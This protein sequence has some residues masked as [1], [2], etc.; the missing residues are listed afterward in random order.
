LGPATR[1]FLIKPSATA[2]IAAITVFV[3]F[4]ATTSAFGTPSGIA[5]W[6]DAAST[7]GTI[8]TMVALLMIAGAF[9]ISAGIT[10]GTTSC[11]LAILATTFKLPVPVAMIGS[12]GV[13]ILIGLT[14]GLL[15]VRT[16][17][18]SFIV[19]LAMF[20][21]L[22]G[23]NVA[24]TV[25]L[26]GGVSVGGIRTATWY[27]VPHSLFASQ[28]VIG[29]VG[30]QVSIVWWLLLTLA[31]SWVLLRTTFGN[32]IQAIG[33]NVLAARAQGVPVGRTKVL[34]F[35]GV[36]CSAWL[37]GTENALRLGSAQASAGSGFELQF[38]VAAVLG[39]CLLFGG[40]GS[41]IGATL[42]AITFGMLQFGITYARW[43]GELY[44]LFLGV[45]LFLA[46][47][48]NTLVRRRLQPG[49]PE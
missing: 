26:T 30:V 37:V 21:V 23:L 38:V 2:I 17:L 46:V 31:A 27:E 45:M 19:T 5:N 13:A 32:W 20:F 10:I 35:V 7:V 39:G 40:R 33:G 9:D 49:L 4:S 11:V 1:G 44:F 25:G 42:G 34:L 18:H 6:L 29:G 12:L 48:L 8:A 14:N 24:M 47:L 28:I 3:Y 22:R 43:P 41:V 15:V 36:S 16:G